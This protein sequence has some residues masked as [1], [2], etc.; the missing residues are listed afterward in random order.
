MPL[1]ERPAVDQ[2]GADLVSGRFGRQHVDVSLHRVFVHGQPVLAVQALERLLRD[3]EQAAFAHLI[4]AQVEK[5]DVP[6]SASFEAAF[7][8]AYAKEL[9]RI[10]RRLERIRVEEALR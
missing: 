3:H 1:R 8:A 2:G 6:Y 7:R 4:R 5:L 9:A 10:D